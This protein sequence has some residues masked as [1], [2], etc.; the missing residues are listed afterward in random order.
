MTVLYENHQRARRARFSIVAAAIWAL[1]CL[2][3]AYALSLGGS[4]SGVIAL[5][6]GVGFLPLVILYFYG[7]S[8]VVRLSREGEEVTIN[9]LGLIAPSELRV[10]L[11][12]IS[13]VAKPE[14]GGI[15]I[16][17]VGRSMPLLV[18]LQAER[19][20]IDAIAALR[21]GAGTQP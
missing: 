17:V 9:T 16:R 2:Y 12:A 8:Y 14:S 11:R 13:E 6:A 21:P 3:W 20:N 15:V 4:Q 18:D 19:I 7:M 10:P 1:G 5:V